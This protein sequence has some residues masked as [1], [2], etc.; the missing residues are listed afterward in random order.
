MKKIIFFSLCL[1]WTL[2]VEAQTLPVPFTDWVKQYHHWKLKTK[3]FQVFVG[4]LYFMRTYEVIRI[5]GEA[6]EYWRDWAHWISGTSHMVGM[7]EFANSRSSGDSSLPLRFFNEFGEQISVYKEEL[8]REGYQSRLNSPEASV[9]TGNKVFYA[10]MPKGDANIELYIVS[11][12]E[13]LSNKGIPIR[14]VPFGELKFN[15]K[16]NEFDFAGR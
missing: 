14:T 12:S 13:M 16:T 1:L 7:Y 9:L 5:N 6:M 10:K 15:K 11:E 2:T 8:V 4:N 3:E